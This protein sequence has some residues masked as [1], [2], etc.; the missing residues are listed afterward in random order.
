[1][2]TVAPATDV[3]E[4]EVRQAI[5]LVGSGAAVR[6]VLCGIG[7]IESAVSAL[8]SMAA[9]AGVRLETEVTEDGCV[10]VVVLRR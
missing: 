6:V 9:D 7:S 8:A 5:A 1:V 10:E 2:V 4:A 3:A